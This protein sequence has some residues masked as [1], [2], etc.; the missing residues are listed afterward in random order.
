MITGFLH[1][2]FCFIIAPCIFLATFFFGHCPGAGFPTSTAGGL[3][4]GLTGLAKP[5]GAFGM[6]GTP[7]LGVSTATATPGL[8]LSLS[9]QPLGATTP[10]FGAA[11]PATTGFPAMSLGMKVE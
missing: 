3:A 11:K 1:P 6:S 8:G 7:T 10:G 9:G 5:G 4:G 2:C